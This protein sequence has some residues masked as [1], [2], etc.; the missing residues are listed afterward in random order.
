[1]ELSI[2]TSTQ[3]ASI[4]LSQEG[5]IRAETTWDAGMQQT[6]ELLPAVESML[7]MMHRT[8]ADTSAVYV[9]L[10]PGTFAGVRIALSTAKGIALSLGVPIVGVGTMTLEAFPFV[11]AGLPVM[12]IRAAGRSEFAFAY[13]GGVDGKCEAVSPI[14]LT[15]FEEVCSAVPQKTIICGDF[16]AELEQRLRSALGPLAVI[17]APAVRLRRASSLAACGWD[18][19]RSGKVDDVASLQPIYLRGPHITTPKA[20]H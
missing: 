14:R 7:A 17:P 2:D 13:F 20:S 8:F 5:F 12:V 6:R 15:T 4:A 11:H 9:S 3:V 19:L 16:G 18:R 10:G 1:M